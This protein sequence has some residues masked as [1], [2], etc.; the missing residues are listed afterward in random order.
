MTVRTTPWAREDLLPIEAQA[1]QD[2]ARSLG[3][4]VELFAETA[5]G[6]YSAKVGDIHVR[7]CASAYAA[8]QSALGRVEA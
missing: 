6:P 7:G 3:V 5:W 4:T 1:I 2:R 8:A